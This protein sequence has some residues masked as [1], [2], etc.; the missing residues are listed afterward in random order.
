MVDK[1]RRLYV[2]IEPD[3]LGSLSS[4]EYR[5]IYAFMRTL[6]WNLGGDFSVSLPYYTPVRGYTTHCDVRDGSFEP[7]M[8]RYTADLRSEGLQASWRGQGFSAALTGLLVSAWINSNYRPKILRIVRDGVLAKCEKMSM[9]GGSGSWTAVIDVPMGSMAKHEQALIG[10]ISELAVSDDF[11]RSDLDMCHMLTGLGFAEAESV[12]RDSA[13]EDRRRSEER[14]RREAEM[15]ELN[16]EMRR[17]DS[18]IDMLEA[19]ISKRE[20]ELRR[21]RVAIE[22]AERRAAEV[23][24]AERGQGRKHIPRTLGVIAT[25]LSPLAQLKGEIAELEGF[26]EEQLDARQELDDRM[27]ELGYEYGETDAAASAGSSSTEEGP[28]TARLKDPEPNSDEFNSKL[29][30]KDDV[31]PLR[32]VLTNGGLPRDADGWTTI[33]DAAA[34]MMLDPGY[35]KELGLSSSMVGLE[36]SPGKDRIRAVEPAGSS[37]RPHPAW[38]CPCSS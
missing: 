35:V 19:E 30:W 28:E 38:G 32:F 5:G 15:R 13:D 14:R 6:D 31:A 18:T 21:T 1:L 10:E 23:R 17:I 33:L 37:R 16:D 20:D 11:N 36:L 9:P 2:Y 25:P 22:E 24:R 4:E 27:F 7:D 34:A 3:I 8:A 29:R 26:L 12:R